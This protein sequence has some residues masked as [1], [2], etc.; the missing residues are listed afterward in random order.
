MIKINKTDI[1]ITRGDTAYIE[2]Y[3]IDITGQPVVLD[4]DDIVRC[5]VRDECDGDLIFEGEIDRNMENNQIIWHIHPYDTEDL[6][7]GTYYWDAQVEYPN[8]D[9]FTFVDV[10]KFNVVKE[11]TLQKD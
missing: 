11:I 4:R 5:Q 2:F 8:G 7:I 10:S 6:D 1:S 3:L 9:I